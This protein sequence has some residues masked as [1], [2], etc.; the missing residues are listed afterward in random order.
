MQVKKAIIKK[1]V[2]QPEHF[3]IPLL[4]N[5]KG[6]R[7]LRVGNHRIIFKIKENQVKIFI[8]EHRSL[9]YKA[10]LQRLGL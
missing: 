3:G 4:E 10:V 5:L 8:I 1:L 7:K 2:E 9:V 6:Y